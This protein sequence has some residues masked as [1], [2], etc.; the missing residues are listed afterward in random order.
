[1]PASGSRLPAAPHRLSWNAIGSAGVYRVELYDERAQS[2]WRSER[3]EA[4]T[5]ELPE[6]I[7]TQLQRGTFLWRVR[8]EGSD[9][10]IG[11]A[12]SYS[13]SSSSRRQP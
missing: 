8:V 12:A 10:E 4:T 2:L 7:R 5:L 6:T 11:R 13:A 9:I 1:M 3:V